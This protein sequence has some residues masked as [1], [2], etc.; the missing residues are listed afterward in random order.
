MLL[1][2]FVP[3]D[4]ESTAY[5]IQE[6]LPRHGLEASCARTRDALRAAFVSV[7][8][9]LHRARDVKTSPRGAETLSDHPARSRYDPCG[10][11][12]I[13]TAQS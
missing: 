8:S 10:K 3:A 6:A 9:R 7:I 11:T 5:D 1:L 12:H 2:L 4:P 13:I